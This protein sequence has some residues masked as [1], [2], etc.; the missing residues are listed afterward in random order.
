MSIGTDGSSDVS[1]TG[2]ANRTP[3]T[4]AMRNTHGMKNTK[5]Q[6]QYDLWCTLEQFSP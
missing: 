6:K 1:V 5:L 4:E 3:A 2:I